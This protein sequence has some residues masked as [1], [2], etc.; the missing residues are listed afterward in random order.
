MGADTIG[1]TAQV[2]VTG[3]YRDCV[4]QALCQCLQCQQLACW[5][6]VMCRVTAL[7]L[8]VVSLSHSWAMGQEPPGTP[9]VAEFP[10]PLVER[11]FRDDTPGTEPARS[12]GVV[13]AGDEQPTGVGAEVA[14]LAAEVE[15]LREEVQQ[16]SDGGQRTEPSDT[17]RPT[18][19]PTGQLQSD[20][21]FFSQ[22]EASLQDFGDIPDGAAFRRA[23][24]R[25]VGRYDAAE[26]Q[27]DMDFALAGRPTF[28]DVFAGL[29]VP[30][31][32][33]VRVG[34]FFEPF[35]L[36]RNTSN[37]FI[38]F[39]ERSLIDDAFVPARN[40]GILLNNVNAAQNL[41]WAVGGFYPDSDFYGDSVGDGGRA[42]TTRVTWLPWYDE[43][44]DGRSLL[45]VGG[46]YSCRHP[47]NVQAVF[48]TRPE[49]RL[50]AATPNVPFFVNTGTLSVENYQLFG[51]EAAWVAGPWSL[52]AE[53]VFANV[54]EE[55]EDLGFGAWYL[56]TSYFLTGEHRPYQRDRGV[57]DRVLPA[58]EFLKSGDGRNVP[59]GPGAWEV[60]F[61]VSH[62]DLN[63]GSVEGGR[64]TDLS[65]R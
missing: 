20:F 24:F 40:L 37:R 16:L 26:Y 4:L 29:Q 57:F 19:R 45:H 7:F 22:D 15:R 39:L 44:C 48:R 2:S 59:R 8:L 46:A 47:N 54:S 63:D 30:A 41:T 60:A 50:G 21:M 34:H 13:A 28:L 18:A 49:A 27:I 35:S 51:L 6:W 65:T 36:E 61:R 12:D 11:R 43:S 42:L 5:R 23:R 10:P 58:T 14:S 56:T 53:H 31:M 33:R 55:T 52:Q 62:I 17:S 1:M 32:G 64:Q 9:V 25:F 3:A 38:T